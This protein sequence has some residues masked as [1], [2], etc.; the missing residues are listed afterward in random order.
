MP[1]FPTVA[2][3]HHQ[4]GNHNARHEIPDNAFRVF[5]PKVSLLRAEIVQG[6]E[7]CHKYRGTH[8]EQ[9]LANRDRGITHNRPVTSDVCCGKDVEIMLVAVT[10][11]NVPSSTPC[12][13]YLKDKK[14]AAGK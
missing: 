5:K 1:E 8:S 4:N 2:F 13:S 6:A 11:L 9:R 7:P 10:G 3:S 12:K 14:K